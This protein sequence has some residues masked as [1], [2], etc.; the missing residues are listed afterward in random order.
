MFVVANHVACINIINHCISFP[1][2]LEKCILLAI[3]I[4][5]IQKKK[6]QNYILNMDIFEILQNINSTICHMEEKEKWMEANWFKDRLQF[7]HFVICLLGKENIV[8]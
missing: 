4:V 5:I 6:I 1:R 2:I 8:I 3:Q 7:K